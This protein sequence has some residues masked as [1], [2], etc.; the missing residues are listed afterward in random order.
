[1]KKTHKKADEIYKGMILM[2]E[3]GER[4]LNP[5]LVKNQAKNCSIA[6][7]NFIRQELEEHPQGMS[8]DFFRMRYWAEIRNYLIKN[9]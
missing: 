4:D 1:M 3:G 2:I 5:E 7:V 8:K 6:C 9:Y